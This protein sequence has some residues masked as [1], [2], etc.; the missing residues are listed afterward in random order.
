MLLPPQL[1]S[2]PDRAPLRSASHR[3]TQDVSLSILLKN[4]S[5]QDGEPYPLSIHR[6]LSVATAMVENSHERIES[7]SYSRVQ[8]SY[9]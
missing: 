7:N 4:K 5:V 2:P 6:L 9:T 1:A 3:T 8:R